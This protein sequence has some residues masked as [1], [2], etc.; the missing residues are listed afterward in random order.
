MQRLVQLHTIRGTRQNLNRAAQR[1][2]AEQQV[3]YAGQLRSLHHMR[4]LT[5]QQHAHA[6]T[7]RHVQARLNHA[8]IAQGNTDTGLRAQQGTLTNGHALLAAAGESA[9]RGGAA[10]HIRAVAHNNALRDAA[11]DHGGAQGAGV[12]VYEALMHHGRTGRQVRAQAQ[13]VAVTNAHAGGH[14]VIH[15]AREL[16]NVAHA[17]VAQLAQTN[18]EV[19]ELGGQHRAVVGPRN[20]CEGAEQSVQVQLVRADQGV[21]EQVQ[22]QVGV[23]GILGSLIQVDGGGAHL[24]AGITRRMLGGQLLQ[25]VRD[26][27]VGGLGEGG[28]GEPGIQDGAGMLAGSNN[29]NQC[30]AGGVTG[31]VFRHAHHYMGRSTPGVRI[32]GV[33]L[34]NRRAASG[35]RGAPNLYRGRMT[36]SPNHHAPLDLN[37]SMPELTRTLLDY[38]S[39]SDHEKELADAVYAALAA[40]PHLHLTRDGD[41][42]IA[43]TEFPPLPGEEGA[44]TRIILA[45]HLDTV[46]LPTVEGS[47]GTVPATVR[48]EDGEYVLYGRGATDMKGGVAVQLKLAAELTARDTDYNLTYIFYDHEEVASELSGLARLIRNHGELITD[49]DFGVLLEPTNGTIE[50]GCNGTMRFFVRTRGLAAHSGRAWR[51]ENAIHALAPALAAL[52]SYEPKTIAVEG[53]DYREGLNA[54]QISGG[55]AGNVIPDAAAMHVNYRFAPDKTLDEAVAH[56]REVFAGYELDFVDLSPAARPGLDTP[57]AASLIEAVGEEPQPKYGWTDVARLSEIGIPAVNFGPGDALLA[58]TDNEHVRFRQLTR[59]HADLRAWLL[60]NQDDE[61]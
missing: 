4:L 31:S 54:V 21:R 52:A 27:Q 5:G 10:A 43:R 61:D 16:I 47:L 25:L 33:R 40:Y 53:L 8:V 57:L 12:E 28:G 51:G 59:C 34:T 19:L 22:T 58:H 29:I 45:G 56:V 13:T 1:I 17:Q 32:A 2:A 55:V 23:H 42:I 44:R 39:V 48:E 3:R 24:S 38:E 15:Q 37:V 14:H 7:G 30:D 50:G 9:H 46:P 35:M 11:L 6:R 49:A 36:V 60:S 41:A 20:I 26:G 18:R